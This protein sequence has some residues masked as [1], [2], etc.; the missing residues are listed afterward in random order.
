MA[1]FFFLINTIIIIILLRAS[2]SRQ[3]KQ[4]YF[5]LTLIESKSYQIYRTLLSILANFS[6]AVF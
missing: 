4:M 6:S 2:S 1:S 5:Y 3:L